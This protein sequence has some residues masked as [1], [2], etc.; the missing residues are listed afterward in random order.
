MEYGGVWDRRMVVFA[1]AW[2]YHVLIFLVQLWG[3]GRTRC[4]RSAWRAMP[5]A[6]HVGSDVGPRTTGGRRAG[7]RPLPVEE[8]VY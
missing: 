4:A 6:P 5:V 7:E 2:V 8:A 3:T 1:T